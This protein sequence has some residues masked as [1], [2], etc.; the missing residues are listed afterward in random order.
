MIWIQKVNRW[1]NFVLKTDIHFV[2]QPL[3]DYL[4]FVDVK[5]NL[6]HKAEVEDTEFFWIKPP[7]VKPRDVNHVNCPIFS[8]GTAL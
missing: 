1:K 5:S 2:F 7:N 6:F 3:I 8:D 4:F